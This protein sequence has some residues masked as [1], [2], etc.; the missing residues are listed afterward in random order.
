MLVLRGTHLYK[1]ADP[2]VDS[3]TEIDL[4]T[5]YT[6]PYD[7]GYTVT[8]ITSL[9]ANPVSGSHEV[10][11]LA[12]GHYTN[13]NPVFGDF[14][15]D[16]IFQSVSDDYGETWTP[17]AIASETVCP[18]AY[19]MYLGAGTMGTKFYDCRG[20][21]DDLG[22]IGYVAIM[23]VIH[24]FSSYANGVSFGRRYNGTWWNDWPNYKRIPCSIRIKGGYGG[25]G[26]ADAPGYLDSLGWLNPIMRCADI[27]WDE[28]WFIACSYSNASPSSQGQISE[29]DTIYTCVGDGNNYPFNMWFMP[30]EDVD[31]HIIVADADVYI[32]SFRDISPLTQTGGEVSDN[33]NYFQAYFPQKGGGSDY[34][35]WP[36]SSKLSQ[37]LW[38]RGIF[39]FWLKDFAAHGGDPAAFE[40]WPHVSCFR[41]PTTEQMMVGLYDD[42]KMVL[43]FNR[44][45]YNMPTPVFSRGIAYECSQPYFISAGADY[46]IMYNDEKILISTYGDWSPPTAGSGAGSTYDVATSKILSVTENVNQFEMSYVDIMLE[47]SDGTFDNP[48]TGALAVLQRGS[49][50]NLSTGYK[51]NSVDRQ[52]VTGRYFVDYMGYI[53][54]PNRSIFAIRAIDGFGLLSKYVFPCGKFY[55]R[56]EA[57]ETYN[58]LHN[59]KFRTFES[60][61]MVLPGDAAAVMPGWLYMWSIWFKKQGGLGSLGLSGGPGQGSGVAMDAMGTI[62]MGA[63]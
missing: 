45:D 40:A 39:K 26:V 63:W 1:Y 55:N 50:I 33:T 53:R 7:L 34:Y 25:C 38:E 48:G 17:W 8:A 43:L 16:T 61:D 18:A 41:L 32:D 3:T 51:I 24:P 57:D 42:D 58:H 29:V 35:G 13:N 44:P 30:I 4:P 27:A 21:Y 52:V 23:N 54:E 49:R 20:A 14:L 9:I 5:T 56:Y 22:N 15:N 19:D 6:D 59:A 12:I 62:G 37:H 31:K 46:V 47:N 60:D 2:L 10:V 11:M 28:D 36:R